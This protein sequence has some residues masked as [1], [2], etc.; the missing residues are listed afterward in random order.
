MTRPTF[1]AEQ[2]QYVD[3]VITRRLAKQRA[4]HQRQ[5]AQLEAEHEAA[6]RRVQAACRASLAAM[7]AACERLAAD[8]E[9]LRAKHSRWLSWFGRR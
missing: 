7:E 2:Q 1:S 4:V 3:A 9:S 5:R 8:N 6:I